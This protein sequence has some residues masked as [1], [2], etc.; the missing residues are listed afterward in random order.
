M[1]LV[2]PSTLLL[3]LVSMTFTAGAP[4]PSFFLPEKGGNSEKDRLVAPKMGWA[5]GEVPP[6][7][8]PYYAGEGET[9]SGGR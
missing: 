7:H 3:L 2:K 5:P 4:P 1:S 9:G 6:A 8:L